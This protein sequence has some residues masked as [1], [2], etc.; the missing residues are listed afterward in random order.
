MKTAIV[1]PVTGVGF[2]SVEEVI[3]YHLCK[4]GVEKEVYFS[5]NNKINN[6]KANI[7]DYV[8]LANKQFAYIGELKKYQHFAEAAT[9]EDAKIY[10][11]KEFENDV[12]LH[13]FLIAN[14]RKIEEDELNTFE[15]VNKSAQAKYGGVGNYIRDTGRLQV[16]YAKK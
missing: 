13:W 5:T 6:K 10:A 2:Y 15:M 1:L 14:L 3:E 16:F 4:G 11:P 9:P 12:N 7:V 8:I